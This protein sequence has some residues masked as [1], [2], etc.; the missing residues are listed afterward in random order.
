M[1][2]ALYPKKRY[3]AFK[4]VGPDRASISPGQAWDHVSNSLFSFLGSLGMSRARFKKIGLDMESKKGVFR[5]SNAMH[6]KALGC[7]AISGAIQ[8]KRAR[9]QILRSS[10]SLKKLLE[11]AAISVPKKTA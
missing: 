9:L 7:L 10:G 6:R 1:A 8:G 5:V 4:I 11:D 2:K 3:V